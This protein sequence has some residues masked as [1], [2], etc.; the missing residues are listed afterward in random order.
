MSE[1]MKA[2][3]LLY[4][5]ARKAPLN[6]ESHEMCFHATNKLEAFIKLHESLSS[7]SQSSDHSSPEPA[8]E[9]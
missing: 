2:L 4:S 5:A 6:A 3:A 7:E 8:Q 1:A 9:P